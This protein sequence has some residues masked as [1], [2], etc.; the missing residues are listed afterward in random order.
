MV[1]RVFSALSKVSRISSS[2]CHRFL[3]MHCLVYVNALAGILK[4]APISGAS[5][6]SFVESRAYSVWDMMYPDYPFNGWSSLLILLVSA[7]S[8][9]HSCQRL[10]KLGH[11]QILSIG[12][13][14]CPT[15]SGVL[16]TM[17]NFTRDPLWFDRVETL[18]QYSGV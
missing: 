9:A 2:N 8:W 7:M 10:L 1:T 17:L 15:F 4:N 16:F 5:I 13:M 11:P 14:A 3:A 6:H 18:N 12:K